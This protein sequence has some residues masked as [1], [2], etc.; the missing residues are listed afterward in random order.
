MH[1]MKSNGVMLINMSV[2]IQEERLSNSSVLT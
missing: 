2:S 1:I